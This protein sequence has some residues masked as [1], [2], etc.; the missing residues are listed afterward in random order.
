MTSKA[1]FGE[2][3]YSPKT[4]ILKNRQDAC[5]TKSVFF[6]SWGVGILPAHKRLIENGGTSQLLQIKN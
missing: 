6:S 3:Y 5:F 2:R 1:V 4:T